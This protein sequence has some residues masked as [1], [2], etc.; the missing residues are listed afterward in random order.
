VDRLVGLRLLAALAYV[1]LL[2]LLFVSYYR[3][4]R[5]A[6]PG[7]IVDYTVA[8]FWIG[9]LSFVPALVIGRWWATLIPLVSFPIAA[10]LLVVGELDEDYA[11]I[12]EDRGGPLGAEWFAAAFIL[13]MFAVPA[14]FLGAG[15][16]HRF[17]RRRR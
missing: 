4:V 8:A 17:R 15:I 9:V 6:P 14:A 16:G 3:E 12:A 2:V 11:A 1:A 5:G 13:C 7:T 10:V